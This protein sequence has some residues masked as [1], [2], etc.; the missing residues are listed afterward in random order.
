MFIGIIEI[1]IEIFESNSL[2]EKRS[3]V[4]SLVRRLKSRYNISI[5]EVSNLDTLNYSTIGISIVSNDRKYIQTNI[6]KIL[7]FIDNDTRLEVKN[8]NYE[9][10]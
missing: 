1:D 6:D 8:I 5:A 3:V 9:I 7:N 4:Q 10:M 2:K